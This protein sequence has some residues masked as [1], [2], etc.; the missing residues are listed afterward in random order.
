M[1]LFMRTDEGFLVEDRVSG[2]VSVVGRLPGKPLSEAPLIVGVERAN[3]T[4]AKYAFGLGPFASESAAFDAFVDA[5]VDSYRRFPDGVMADPSV[6]KRRLL[7]RVRTIIVPRELDR[8]LGFLVLNVAWRA[9]DSGENI[10][11]A[12]SELW[13]RLKPTSSGGENI[14]AKL[15]VQKAERKRSAFVTA[16]LVSEDAARKRRVEAIVPSR[17]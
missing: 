14:D 9:A 1:R 16:K 13:K 2:V 4:E 15:S 3:A 12:V 11:G 8:D 5:F 17:G 6:E 7:R 10:A